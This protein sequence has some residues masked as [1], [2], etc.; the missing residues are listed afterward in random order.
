MGVV[1]QLRWFLSWMCWENVSVTLLI[2]C[3]VRDVR[4]SAELPGLFLP[5]A[6]RQSM[7]E[8]GDALNQALSLR[9]EPWV[10]LL[11]GWLFCGSSS[12]F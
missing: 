7:N 10:L 11:R 8:E 1:L 3:S 5:C 9:R 12:P 6:Q 2:N 4:E